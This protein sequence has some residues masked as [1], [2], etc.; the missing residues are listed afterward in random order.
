MKNSYRFFANKD[1]EYYPCHKG[2]KD[3]N[4]MFCYCPFYRDKKCLGNAKYINTNGKIIK[5]CSNCLFPHIPENYDIII[6]EICKYF[7]D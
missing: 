6:G 1:C 2:L 7:T 5:D 3:F 4:C